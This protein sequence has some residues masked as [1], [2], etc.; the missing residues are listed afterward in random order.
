M[1]RPHDK[2]NAVVSLLRRWCFTSKS[3]IKNLAKKVQGFRNWILDPRSLISKLEPR[4]SKKSRLVD[5]VS[6][7]DCQLTLYGTVTA[8]PWNLRNWIISPWW[9][10]GMFNFI[11]K[12]A[13]SM[14]FLAFWICINIQFVPVSRRKWT[15]FCGNYFFA[16]EPAGN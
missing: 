10:M 11:L 14:F 2:C 6:S 7:E 16:Q 3:L 8:L 4:F 13:V 12:C 5:R 1:R 9:E 15:P